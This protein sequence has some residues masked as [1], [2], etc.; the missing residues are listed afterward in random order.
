[1]TAAVG[2]ALALEWGATP[3]AGVREK[4]IALNG[5]PIDVTDDDDDGWRALLADEAAQNEVTISVNGVTKDDTLRAA[6]FGTRTSAMTVTFPDG[7]TISGNF[8][9]QSYTETGAYN[10]AVT[11][12][13]EFQ[14]SGIVTYT[15]PA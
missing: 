8:F 15:P 6:W 11:F 7:G 1:M 4:S 10:D 9:L 5:E 13:A 12:E 14:S 3:V 2:R